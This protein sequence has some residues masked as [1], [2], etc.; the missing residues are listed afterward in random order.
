MGQ[1]GRLRRTRPRRTRSRPAPTGRAC[2]TCAC[3]KARRTRAHDLRSKAVGEPPLMLAI[4]VLHAIPTRSRASRTTRCA[5]GSP[6]GDARE[7]PQDARGIAVAASC[8]RGA[9]GS[10]TEFLTRVCED[11]L[12]AGEPVALVS[13][14]VAKGSTPRESGARMLVT[15]RASAGTIGGGRLEFR[16][17][18]PGAGAARG[19]RGACGT[20]HAARPRNRPMLRRPRHLAL[21]AAWTRP[22]W[23]SWQPAE[24]AEA[25]KLPS[26]LL[27]G[28]GHVGQALASAL[29]PLPVRL[30]WIDERAEVFPARTPEGVRRSRLITF[31][32]RSRP[33]RVGLRISS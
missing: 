11:W 3:S 7:G 6:A 25:R 26:V 5:R 13:V 18:R 21:R 8:I 19:W 1:A 30:S 2:S 4:S 17:D 14:A 28:A 10:V 24:A 27:F 20:P 29:A 22:A 9:G 32:T 12:A 15:E 16:G 31:S 33:H 23:R